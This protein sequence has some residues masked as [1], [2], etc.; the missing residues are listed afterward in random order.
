MGG[1][2]KGLLLHAGQPLVE[3]VIARLRPQVSGLLISANRNLDAYRAYG[4]PVLT[5]LTDQRLGPL[6]GL[7]AG[8]QACTTDWLLACP[9][10]C[11]A[12]PPDL[13]TRLFEGAGNAGADMAVAT[14]AEGLQPAIQ[15]LRRTQ[16]AALN[17]FLAR[18]ER[19]VGY[20]CK[21]QGA[22]E[23][24]FDDSAAFRNFNTPDS[25]D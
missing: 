16:L 12:L 15:L 17:D 11:P 2:D 19:R 23:V 20:W 24:R 5:D 1:A 8:L 4:F 22:V 9:C 13:A 6:A 18:G 7:Q 25:L 14:T 10:D 21:Q 3:H